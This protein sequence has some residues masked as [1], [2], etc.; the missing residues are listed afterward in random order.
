MTDEKLIDVLQEI[1]TEISN[2]RPGGLA[3][4]GSKAARDRDGILWEAQSIVQRKINSIAVFEKAHAPTDDERE[5]LVKS[6][7]GWDLVEVALN[8][9][10]ASRVITDLAN[11]LDAAL[12][13]IAAQEPQR[14]P[15]DAQVLAA[16]IAY[17]GDEKSTHLLGSKE[18]MRAAL[19]AAGGVR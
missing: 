5:A 16:L 1:A 19:R 14:E 13:R 10:G 11:R 2:L 6:Y 18:G 17:W 9:N 4:L 3:V 8:P 12:R 15:T 7:E